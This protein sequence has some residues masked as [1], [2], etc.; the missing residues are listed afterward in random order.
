MASLESS[1]EGE[2]IE[3]SSRSRSH[4]PRGLKRSR[5][6]SPRDIDYRPPPRDREYRPTRP[7]HSRDPRR[8][9]VRYEDAL[10]YDDHDDSKYSDLKYVQTLSR[11]DTP[12]YNDWSRDHDRDRRR[13]DRGDRTRPREKSR[14]RRRPRY[15]SRSPWRSPYSGSLCRG[16]RQDDNRR[17]LGYDD[18]RS[19]RARTPKYG[20]NGA[21][22]P[23]DQ[24]WSSSLRPNN[25]FDRC[26]TREAKHEKDLASAARASITADAA[27]DMYVSPHAVSAVFLTFADSGRSR[28]PHN[29]V[30]DKMDIDATPPILKEQPIVEEEP[31]PIDEDAE[32]ERRKRRREELLAK[33]RTETASASPFPARLDTPLTANGHA[34]SALV[35][36]LASEVASPRDST[37]GAQDGVTPPSLDLM[38]DQNLAKA[39]T[40]AA[41]EDGPSAADYDPTIDMKEDGL[42]QEARHANVGLHGEVFP[43]VEQK[44]AKEESSRRVGDDED[45]ED[46]DMFADDFDE[47]KYAA[48]R[49]VGQKAAGQGGSVAPGQAILEGDD[50]DGYY[51]IRIGEVLNGRYQIET[52]LGRGMFSGVARAKD[53]MTGQQVAIKIMRNND[54]LRKG[55]F[56]EIAIL[57][58]INKADPDSRRHVVKFE[59]H[60]DFK[61]HLCMVFENLSLNLREV[62]RKFGNNVGLNLQ[63]VRVYARQIFVALAHFKACS[64]IHAD[65]KPDNILVSE[66]RSTLKICDLGTAIDRSDPA[67]AH[68]E[69]SPYLISR[70]YRA[71][72]IILGMPFDHAVDVWSIGCTLF[73]LY[74]GKILFTGESNNQMLKTMMEI[75]GKFSS[76]L[77]RK[78]QLAH[79]HFDE[80]G[81]FISVER[82]RLQ[83]GKV[84]STFP[85]AINLSLLFAIFPRFAESTPISMITYIFI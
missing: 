3:R 34:S 41:V 75:R 9:H 59:R 52:A 58:K 46:F 56:T 11:H 70:F 4:S 25:N 81:N 31:E 43:S 6:P 69:V 50:K 61:G 24:K 55:G 76:K 32:I 67:T 16:Y 68:N 7:P 66:N 38:S 10:Q 19:E 5:Q 65:L 83:P 21:R 18:T 45:D 84:C 47:D 1:D 13:E 49:Q 51:K 54:A 63:A 12:E 22:T 8:F 30:Y 39:H 42:R 77:Y 28:E 71:P 44:E 14:D 74:T 26:E 72:E 60:F 20:E 40:Q 62:L 35:S 53:V 78:G 36:A 29:S 73:E 64:I 79:Q 23:R 37:P 15:R 33:S 85:F 2:I 17:G 48:P 27:Q 57:Q 82:D 80:K